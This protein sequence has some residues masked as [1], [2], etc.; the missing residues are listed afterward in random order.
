MTVFNTQRTRDTSEKLELNF[1]LV[2]NPKSWM[3]R[4]K[5][6]R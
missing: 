3:L 2:A 6:K 5:R 1:K 4:R